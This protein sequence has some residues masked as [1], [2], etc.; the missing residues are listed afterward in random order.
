MPKFRKKPV[1][2]DA[3]RWQGEEVP[4]FDRISVGRDELS[5][6]H[7]NLVIRTL[8]GTVYAAEGDWVLKGVAGEF[9]PC[10]DDIFRATYEPA[11]LEAERALKGLNYAP[12]WF[13]DP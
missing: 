12:G 7:Y 8:E 6:E 11:D 9:Y 5:N 4:G 3:F 1:V 13:F 2:I 10:R